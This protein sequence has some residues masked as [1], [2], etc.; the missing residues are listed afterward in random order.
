[1][2]IKVRPQFWEKVG[3]FFIVSIPFLIGTYLILD[4]KYWYWSDELKWG[5]AIILGF[6][7]GGLVTGIRELHLHPK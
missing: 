4:A 1:M 5:I 3:L 6:F 2:A 7:V